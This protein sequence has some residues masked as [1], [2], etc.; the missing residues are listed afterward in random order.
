ELTGPTPEFFNNYGAVLCCGGHLD[1]GRQLIE[2][3]QD[4][5]EAQAN[6]KLIE[7]IEALGC[8]SHFDFHMAEIAH[9]VIYEARRTYALVMNEGGEFVCTSEHPQPFWCASQLPRENRAP[10]LEDDEA[11][12]VWSAPMLNAGGFADEARNFLLGLAEQE[13]PMKT[14]PFEEEI[15]DEMNS[16]DTALLG[17]FTETPM[18]ENYI[19]VQHVIPGRPILNGPGAIA[20]VARAMFETDSVPAEWIPRLN[21]MDEI[22]VPSDFNIETFEQAG[23]RSEKLYKVPGS[24]DMNCYLDAEPLQERQCG[25]QF[26]SMFAWGMRKGWDVLLRAYI[27]EFGEDEDVCLFLKLSPGSGL[28]LP[29]IE[30]RI[31]EFIKDTLGRDPAHTPEIVLLKQVLTETQMPQLY[32]AMDAFVLPTRG[33]GWGRVYMEAMASGLPTIGTSWSGNT[34]FMNEENSY[35]IRSSVAE[36]SPEA[37]AEEPLFQGHRWAEPSAEHLR[38][39]MRG[40]FENREES[41]RKGQVAREYVTENYSRERVAEH[42]KDRLEVIRLQKRSAD[43]NRLL[44]KA[45][46]NG[47]D[48]F[49]MD[50]RS[51]I[52]GLDQLGI[53]MRIESNADELARRDSELMSSTMK[54]QLESISKVGLA[55][56]YICV[57]NFWP[58]S[59]EPDPDAAYNIARV[60]FET[61]RL[62]LAWVQGCN[63]M[64]EIWVPSGF[65]IETFG[66]SG[67]DR[68]KLHK[69]SPAIDMDL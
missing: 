61:D 35:L 9:P 69:I 53:T 7:K 10:V 16:P 56:N 8:G 29:Q 60:Q 57:Q 52:L 24:I 44:W 20:N 11:M 19:H 55:E 36:V 65:N 43:P 14:N 58:G 40:V 3:A 12:L 47:L 54:F 42:I 63:A 5:P 45:P 31:Q 62:P 18:P 30:Q 41:R 67:V 25:F 68:R 17:S 49:S 22:W 4:L 50:S 64:D 15:T 38:S 48:A 23:I 26:L 13:V 6:L 2:K 39:L 32:Q 1:E 46:V 28:S 33:E 34:E 51:H 66:F 27:E 21:D 59:H 37:V